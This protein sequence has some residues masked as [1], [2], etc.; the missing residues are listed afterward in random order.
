MMEF[1]GRKEA[2]LQPVHQ[3]EDLRISHISSKRKRPR[4]AKHGRG[5][6]EFSQKQKP[7]GNSQRFQKLIVTGSKTVF[8]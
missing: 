3:R 2:A 4:T 8:R 1:R 6:L 7:P 5:R